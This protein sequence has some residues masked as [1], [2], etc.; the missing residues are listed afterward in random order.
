MARRE[1]GTHV[2][3]FLNDGCGGLLLAWTACCVGE[4]L[5]TS[6]STT[7]SMALKAWLGSPMDDDGKGDVEIEA[8]PSR[9]VTLA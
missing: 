7:E 9:C 8:K 4:Y 1:Q 2:T 3:R 5:G 6:V